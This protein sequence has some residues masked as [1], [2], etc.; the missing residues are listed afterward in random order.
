MAIDEAIPARY[1][2][3]KSQYFNVFKKITRLYLAG[4]AVDEA[5]P[6]RYNHIY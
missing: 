4:I 1:F 2:F 5:I 3:S 6:A